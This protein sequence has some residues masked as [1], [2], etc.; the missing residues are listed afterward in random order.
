MIKTQNNFNKLFF[1]VKK[2]NIFLIPLL[3]IGI[4]IVLPQI[5]ITNYAQ[6]TITSKFI[7]FIYSCIVIG[8]I[9]IFFT[10]LFKAKTI[11]ISKLDITLLMLI[12]YITFNRYFI[13]TEYSFSIR[14][15]ELLGLGILYLA[16]RNISINSY[17]WLLLAIIVSGIIQAVYGNLQ[18]FGY[19]PSNHS[20][21]KINGSFFNPGPYAGFL[22]AVWPIALAMYLFKEQF[23]T[24]L[25]LPFSNKTKL[26]HTVIYYILNYVPIIGIVTVVLV[27]PASRSR[28]A[29]LSV[30]ISTI[31]LIEYR[32][33]ILKR[34]FGKMSTAKKTSLIVLSVSIMCVVLYSVYHLKKRSSDGRLFIWDITTNIIKDNSITGVG[35]DR[36]KAYYMDYQANYFNVNGETEEVLVA[37][38]TY[39]AFNEFLQFTAEEGIVGVLLLAVISFFILKI[40]VAEKQL[41]ILQLILA[42]LIAIAV[43]ANFS[44]PMQILPIKFVLIV[45]LS[46]LGQLEAKKWSF[47]TH[48]TLKKYGAFFSKLVS[49]S[50]IFF[51]IVK[52]TVYFKTIDQA[53]KD[54]QSAL[55]I[56]Q[57]G[58]Y[59]G[60]I[61]DYVKAYPILKKEGDFLMNYGKT[62]SIAKQY[63]KAVVVLEEAKQHL[64]T[65]I[66]ETA[67]GDAYKGLK[68]YDK[69][70]TA[71]LNAANMIPV[72]FYPLYL[73]AKLYD[74]GGESK[75]AIAMANRIL[76][77]EIKVPSTAIKEIQLEMKEIINR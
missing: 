36:F 39:Y 33:K 52:G 44:Y 67:L 35:I 13:Q 30:I 15:I 5:N 2:G 45:L 61:E 55:T 25:Q 1:L 72:R 37:D 65:T 57:Y 38:N 63:D 46:L 51:G 56:Y 43:F 49:A 7:V 11:H 3:L 28:A 42:G 9:H 27:L 24:Y 8:S 14:Y 17:T 20:E 73:L 75:K 47:L 76:E 32:Y 26:L 6:S 77:K 18:L 59:E 58:D 31:V 23:V 66:I 53:Y 69:A 41:P 16:L 62:L 29:W 10:V 48:T 34:V 74:E 54:W 70:E 21:F 12:I 71:Y 64:N 19:Y 60:A 40:K 22:A 68:E 4:L 50:F